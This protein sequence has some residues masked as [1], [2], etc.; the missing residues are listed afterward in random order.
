MMQK[1]YFEAQ[2]ASTL[3]SRGY[4][5]ERFGHGENARTDAKNRAHDKR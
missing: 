1:G 3:K 2:A 5:L 4:A